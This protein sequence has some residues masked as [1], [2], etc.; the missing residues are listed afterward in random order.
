[1]IDKPK[2]SEIIAHQFSSIA[3]IDKP[4]TNIEELLKNPSNGR[5]LKVS[6]RNKFNKH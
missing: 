6:A 4:K 5:Y 2:S 1:M 3:M